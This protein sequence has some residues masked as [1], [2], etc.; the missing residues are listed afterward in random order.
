MIGP[1]NTHWISS[2][3]ASVKK[4]GY[5][6]PMK[7]SSR[8][9]SATGMK[10]NTDYQPSVDDLIETRGNGF[11]MYFDP[12]PDTTRRLQHLGENRDHWVRR[13][14]VRLANWLRNL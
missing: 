8:V 14:L 5:H 13:L 2:L 1:M 4:D 11:R 6:F 9:T 7:H 12:D 10:P 3:T